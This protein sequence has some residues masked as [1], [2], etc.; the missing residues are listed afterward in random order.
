MILIFV[1]DI[2]LYLPPIGY[3]NHYIKGDVCESKLATLASAVNEISYSLKYIFW[4]KK[5]RSVNL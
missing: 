1:V 2:H 3:I 5:N 4:K